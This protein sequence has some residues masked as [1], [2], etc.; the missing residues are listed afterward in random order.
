VG[1]VR[2]QES[3]SDVLVGL[4]AQL[5]KTFIVPP[6]PKGHERGSCILPLR[7]DLSA[8]QA[9][10]PEPK[11]GLLDYYQR[12]YVMTGVAFCMVVHVYRVPDA[13]GL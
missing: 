5:L 3:S 7:P 13:G 1:D 8:S 12:R 2:A 11:V 4:S 10:Y 6:L 9:P